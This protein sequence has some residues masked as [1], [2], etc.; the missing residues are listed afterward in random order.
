MVSS[1]HWLWA[2]FKVDGSNE[3]GGRI[4]ALPSFIIV[5]HEYLPFLHSSLSEQKDCGFSINLA[6]H[7]SNVLVLSLWALDWVVDAV[8]ETSGICMFFRH[9]G[10][11]S[12]LILSTEKL[13]DG[14]VSDWLD[15]F[16]GPHLPEVLCDKSKIRK[17]TRRLD[18][19][20]LARVMQ[21][22]KRR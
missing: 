10:E 16:V 20:P 19:E 15:L 21:H 18:V 5:K 11:A 4:E 14:I 8:E 22:F 9:D 6:A 7:S 2:L 1:L 3:M 12:T 13:H 17:V